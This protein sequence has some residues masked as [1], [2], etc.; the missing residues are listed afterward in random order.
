MAKR[1]LTKQQQTRI[2][3]QQNHRRKQLHAP[4]PDKVDT[5]TSDAPEQA[6]MVIA[7]FGATLIVENEQG[8]T[9]RC[10]LRQNI[11]TLVSGDRIVW[12]QLDEETGVIVA[13]QER[14]SFLARPDRRGKAKIIAANIDQIMIVSAC[15]PAPN[16][17]LIDRYLVAAETAHITP[18]IIFN[19][20]DLLGQANTQEIEQ[21]LM[22]YQ[23]LG[24][25]LLYTSTKQAHG[26]DILQSCLQ[27]KTSV[28]VG[29]S[30]VGKSSLINTL[31][32]EA[33]ALVGE[34]SQ[35]TQKGRHTTTMAQLYHLPSGGQ[36]IDS[37]GIREFGLWQV[38]QQQ[39]ADGFRE[40]HPFLGQCR[41]RDCLH[42][43]E[44]GCLVREN[45]ATGKI[46]E[47]RWQSYRRI[48]ESLRE[49]G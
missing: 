20:T 26:M 5:S 23:D 18:V 9:F 4:S 30:G 46:T 31:L 36:I 41:F 42:E 27:D 34:V 47:Q 3:Q 10:T 39:L 43:D 29:Q 12:Q 33:M 17:R 16:T 14:S 38:T 32:P 48:L 13:L 40:F 15:K 1:K 49:M 24:Y 22:P 21:Q 45:V 44:P 28:F 25:Q 35:S 37:P 2:Q 8:Q 6:G 11:P 19:K 7:N